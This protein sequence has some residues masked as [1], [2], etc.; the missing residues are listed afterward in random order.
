MV[1]R[2]RLSPRWTC[3]RLHDAA[4]VASGC[5]WTIVRT[6]SRLGVAHRGVRP[7]P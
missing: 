7:P 3:S 2:R 4:S 1:G 5:S 6:S